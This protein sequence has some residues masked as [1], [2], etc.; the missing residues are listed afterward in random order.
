MLLL[1]EPIGTLDAQT[2]M[3]ELLLNVYQKNQ[4]TVLSI[5][6]AAVKSFYFLTGS[7]Q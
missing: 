5:T 6:P 7:M 3:Q 4:I 1:D 2:Q